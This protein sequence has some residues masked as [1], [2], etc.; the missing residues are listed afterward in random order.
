MFL[1][2]G[3]RHDARL[4]FGSRVWG[5]V[6]FGGRGCF[7]VAVRCGGCGGG[8][9]VAR[10]DARK[11]ADMSGLTNWQRVAIEHWTLIP[12]EQAR[13]IFAHRTVLGSLVLTARA[14]WG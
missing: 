6:L 13:P 10:V 9:P 5:G 3:A 8:W 1:L 14:G 12:E 4:W 7:G 11:A 2:W